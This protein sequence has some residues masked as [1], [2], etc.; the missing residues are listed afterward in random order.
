MTYVRGISLDAM[1]K[2]PSLNSDP[3]VVPFVSL[4][5]RYAIVWRR[6]ESRL[7]LARAGSGESVG[8]TGEAVG[9]AGRVGGR[10]GRAV[11]GVWSRMWAGSGGSAGGATVETRPQRGGVPQLKEQDLVSEKPGELKVD[12]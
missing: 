8:G 5:P 7:L 9:G 3:R 2:I 1:Q 4:C 11:G 6:P 12:F 10:A